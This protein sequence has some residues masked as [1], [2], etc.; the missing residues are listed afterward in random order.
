MSAS[1]LVEKSTSW[2]CGVASVSMPQAAMKRSARSMLG[3]HLARSG[4]LRGSRPRTPGSRRAPVSRSAKPPLV[5]ARS[6]FSVDARL[7]VG[8]EQAFGVGVAGG[9]GEGDVVDHVAPE[10]RQLDA[11]DRLGGR[12]T[13]LGELAGDASDL[14][15]GDTRRVGEHDR[16]LEDDLQLVADGVGA[17]RVE[18]F[19]A[20]AGL[21]QERPAGGHLGQVGGESSG[22]AG[23][24]ERR[25]RGQL[26]DRGVERG[27]I[28]PVRL[29]DGR[30]L[31][32]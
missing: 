22:L 14:H 32:P 2:S 28:R 23:E 15:H 10:R 27:G 16:H 5:N 19:G 29:L 24:D 6:R 17:E 21:E 26:L 11:V 8:G 4:A 3:G 1:W 30:E 7:V 20:V 13:G 9:G 12:R 18:R 25:H 31:P